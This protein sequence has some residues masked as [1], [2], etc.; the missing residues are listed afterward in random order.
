M[1]N[2]QRDWVDTGQPLWLFARAADDVRP[3]P[4]KQQDA[5]PGETP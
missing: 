2:Q 5:S 1:R 4:N 3:S